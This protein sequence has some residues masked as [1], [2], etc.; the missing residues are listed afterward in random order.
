MHDF[1][2][3]GELHIALHEYPE[4]GWAPPGVETKALLWLL[5]PDLQKGRFY[6][7]LEF[8]VVEG[9]VVGHG[10]VIAVLNRE[11]AGDP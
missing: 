11:L 9:G 1:G 6:P 3:T 7:G 8:T 5:A 4:S 10:H 2:L